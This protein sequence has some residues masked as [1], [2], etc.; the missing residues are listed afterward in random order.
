[1]KDFLHVSKA[2]VIDAT[3]SCRRVRSCEHVTGQSHNTFPAAPQEKTRRHAG[4]ES[5]VSQ[6]CPLSVTKIVCNL[7]S[8]TFV[9]H[10]APTGHDCAG[11]NV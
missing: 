2:G 3:S 8:F 7:V 11:E 10:S 1:M 9:T 6:G 5:E 4:C